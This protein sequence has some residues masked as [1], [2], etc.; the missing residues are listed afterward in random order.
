LTESLSRLRG[1]ALKCLLDLG[2]SFDQAIELGQELAADC[3]EAGRPGEANG[4]LQL[5]D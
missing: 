3:E 4:L 5:G 2:D 1:W